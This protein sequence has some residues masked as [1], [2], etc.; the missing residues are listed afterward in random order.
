MENT[1]QTPTT[2]PLQIETYISQAEGGM[3]D[4]KIFLLPIFWQKNVFMYTV[5]ESAISLVNSSL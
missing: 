2:Y 5:A 3:V 1:K 4:P